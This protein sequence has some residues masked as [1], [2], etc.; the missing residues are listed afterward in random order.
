LIESY[1]YVTGLVEDKKTTIGRLRKILFGSKTEKTKDILGDQPQESPSAGATEEKQAPESP[2][3]STNAETTTPK[4]GHGRNGAKEYTGA[5]K[6]EVPHE[7]LK[8]RDR[9]PICGKGK[10]YILPEPKTLIRLVGQAPIM[11]TLYELQRLRCNLCLKVFVAKPPDD[12]GEEK[13]DPSSAAMIGLLNYGSGLP[14]NRLEG[15][16]RNLGIPLPASTQWDIVEESSGHLEPVFEELIRQGAQGDVLYNDDTDATILK[17]PAKGNVADEEN[18]QERKGVFTSGIVSTKEGRKIALFFTGHRHAG[19]NL[20]AVLSRRA[21]EMKAPIQM[22]DALSKNVPAAFK[23]ILAHCLAHSRRR[24]VDVVESF[25][26]ACRFVLESLKE[27][28]R[29]DAIARERN[30]SPEGRLALHQSESA[31]VMDRLHRWLK[32][33]FEQRLVEPNSGLGEAIQYMTKHW[34]KLTIFLR[35]PGAPL[36]NNCVERALKKAIIHRKNSLFYRTENGARVGDTFM[37]LIYAAELAGV[38]AFGYLTAILENRR[39][40]RKDPAGWMP[41]NYRQ[42]PELPTA[43]ATTTA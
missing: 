32:E 19:E 18:A 6:V 14:F 15:L 30:L 40:V 39:A 43:S 21:A 29:V 35:V 8:V 2:E 9:C 5:H 27:V 37:S 10:L 28:Y 17:L 36:D 24:F 11:A 42:N 26:D 41:W 12:V 31:P 1:R 25:P 3:V 22:C 20:S 34:E 7:C 13:Y 23:V 38:G 4:K 33:Q 16:Q